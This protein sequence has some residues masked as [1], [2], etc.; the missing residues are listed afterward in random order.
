[1]KASLCD[2]TFKVGRLNVGKSKVE[3]FRYVKL[4]EEDYS[5]SKNNC[6]KISWRRRPDAIKVNRLRFVNKRGLIMSTSLSPLTK[7]L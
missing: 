6:H 5:I 7:K 2:K 3:A 4:K 1:M